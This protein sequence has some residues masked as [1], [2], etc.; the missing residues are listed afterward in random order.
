MQKP[1]IL[2]SNKLYQPEESRVATVWEH[3]QSTFHLTT[4]LQ[5]YI[6]GSLLNVQ[7]QFR[8]K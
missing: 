8:H 2:A 5:Y 4:K 3:L 7:S 1:A 6:L